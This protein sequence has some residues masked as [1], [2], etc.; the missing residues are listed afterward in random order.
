MYPCG[1]GGI[2]MAKVHPYTNGKDE[3]IMWAFFCPGCQY[4]HA[5]AV[6]QYQVGGNPQWDF[7]GDPDKPTFS[8]SL[9][10]FG[11][12]Q[13]RRCHTFI[14]NGQIQFLDDCFHDLKGQTVDLPDCED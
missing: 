10:V 8:P 11:S 7:N 5:L 6:T 4:D 3:I 12:D 2:D 14:K 13:S 1:G 9:L